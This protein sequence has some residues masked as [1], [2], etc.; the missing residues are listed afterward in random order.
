VIETLREVPL[1]LKRQSV[2]GRVRRGSLRA[3]TPGGAERDSNVVDGVR[4]VYPLYRS[5]LHG[6]KL[7]DPEPLEVAAQPRSYVR[8]H[9]IFPVLVRTFDEMK[10]LAAE[11][12][13]AVTVILASTATRIYASCCEGLPTPSDQ[14]HVLDGASAID[15]M[16]SDLVDADATPLDFEANPSIAP[17]VDA[18]DVVGVRSSAIVTVNAANA[19]DAITRPAPSAL[20]VGVSR[21]P[22]KDE[23][24]CAGPR[25]AASDAEKL[26]T[27]L[28]GEAQILRTAS[29]GSSDPDMQALRGR[30]DEGSGRSRSAVDCSRSRRGSRAARHPFNPERCRADSRQISARSSASN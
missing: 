30:L 15:L 24:S 4:I 5:A 26:E 2:I 3:T 16:T 18:E 14:P 22:T 20:G 11:Y 8:E 1:A 23:R 7:F 12:H 28:H 25:A 19:N 29:S 17:V 21:C 13:F 6:P 10:A 9:Q 27:V